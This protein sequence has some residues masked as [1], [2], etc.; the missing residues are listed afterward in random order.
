MSAR[1]ET[2][3]RPQVLDAM[4]AAARISQGHVPGLAA[5][6]GGEGCLPLPCA[7]RKLFRTPRIWKPG[8]P[9]SEAPHRKP[10]S[11]APPRKPR[12][13]A[14]EGPWLSPA[15]AHDEMGT[16]CGLQARNAAAEEELDFHLEL[17]FIDEWLP[18]LPG[19]M[20]Y[21]GY[22]CQAAGSNEPSTSHA[23]SLQ[24]LVDDI[25]WT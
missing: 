17:D 25:H 21:I 16:S 14:L 20:G 10:G 19:R 2:A 11:F 6:L 22:L 13:C 5:D 3:S 18:R 8:S 12:I 24:S 23:R 4:D 1:R 9:A 7:P 15:P